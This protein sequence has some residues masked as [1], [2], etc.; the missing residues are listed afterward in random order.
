[1]HSRTVIENQAPAKPRSFSQRSWGFLRLY[2]PEDWADDAARRATCHVPPEVKFQE[3]WRIVLDL[4]DRSLPGLPHGGI[5][6]DDEFGR[7]AKFRAACGSGQ[8]I[9]A[10]LVKQSGPT[11]VT[12][13]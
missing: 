4:L 2:L 5:V 13:T 1:M 12:S 3:K 7:A 8:A 10:H 11:W 6:G 9:R